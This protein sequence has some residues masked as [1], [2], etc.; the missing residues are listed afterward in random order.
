MLQALDLSGTGM[1]L[2]R[3]GL[4]LSRAGMAPSHP[5]D[6]VPAQLASRSVHRLD[7]TGRSDPREEEEGEEEGDESSSFRRSR[8]ASSTPWRT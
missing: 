1:T 6:S 3:A 7:R 2:F 8:T 5:P 4:A